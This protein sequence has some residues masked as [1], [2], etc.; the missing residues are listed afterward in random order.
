MR[1][2][3]GAQRDAP[4]ITLEPSVLSSRVT[5]MH[6]APR[7]A[8]TPDMKRQPMG[9]GAGMFVCALNRNSLILICNERTARNAKQPFFT[10]GSGVRTHRG[11]YPACFIAFRIEQQQPWIY[12]TIAHGGGSVQDHDIVP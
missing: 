2:A 8:K 12:C 5:E 3:L 10:F 6:A 11:M 4:R 7:G 1:L 9:V